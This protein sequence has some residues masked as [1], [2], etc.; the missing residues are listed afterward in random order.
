M[1]WLLSTLQTCFRNTPE[2]FCARLL[3][4]VTLKLVE[5]DDLIQVFSEHLSGTFWPEID[6][7]VAKL[8][9]GGV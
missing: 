4:A 5:D 8:V 6:R 1:W 7:K 2:N 3:F 9:L